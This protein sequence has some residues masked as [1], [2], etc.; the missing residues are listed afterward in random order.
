MKL[1]VEMGIE[2]LVVAVTAYLAT[3]QLEVAH[4]Q[5]V[6]EA[7]TS[8]L[9]VGD[10]DTPGVVISVQA[11]HTRLSSANALATPEVAPGPIT[12]AKAP[13][14]GSLTYAELTNPDGSDERVAPTKEQILQEAERE[15]QEILRQSNSFKLAHNE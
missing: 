4:P 13:S 5:A 11:I 7:V 15:L 12:S 14:Q 2:D 8:M 6:R 3:M 1:K 10:D 9:C